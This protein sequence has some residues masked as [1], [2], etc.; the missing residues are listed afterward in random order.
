MYNVGFGD[1]FLL[2][3][4]YR[5]Q[6]GGDRHVLIDFGSFPR[7][8]GAPKNFMERVA[9]DIATR[10]QGGRLAVVAT[11]RHADHISGFATNA[12]HTASG[13]IIAA[14]KPEI[15]IQPWTEHPDA[16][17]DAHRAPALRRAAREFHRSLQALEGLA[18]GLV[19]DRRR[20][21]SFLAT[22]VRDQLAF[23]GENSISNKSAVKNLMR[24]GRRKPRYVHAGAQSGLTN[25][26]P[27]VKVR[28]L[29]PPTFEQAPEIRAYARKSDE[30]WVRL[31]RLVALDP[32]GDRASKS[33]NGALFGRVARHGTAGA[34]AHAAWFIKRLR[35]TYEEELLSIV[36]FLDDVLNN[37]S[38]ILLF[39]VGRQKLLFPGDAQLE[40]WSYALRK[41]R[42]RLKGVTVYKVG[43]HGSL[44]A[45]PKT[46][47]R[48]MTDGDAAV[49]P[50][51]FV[52]LMSSR[53]NV[54]GGKH[55][56]P[57]EVPR[58]PLVTALRERSRLV[59]T[60]DRDDFGVAQQVQ[61]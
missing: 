54:H 15:V 32:G 41:F 43:H 50:D 38:L 60:L 4:P 52:T 37:T 31:Q 47:W 8:K 9:R 16:A 11:H 6:D 23:L 13:D 35:R 56:R 17:T 10:C 59:T 36:T 20:L 39:E 12:K 7:P 5:Q 49:A 28:V 46:L 1:C 44:N 30:Y 58:G 21:P 18:A 2:T 34:P 33:G 42:A 48:I 26:L 55:G 45:T 22:D 29:G 27:G 51:H 25:V 24:M 57:T 19:A 3:F 53:S 14:I 40:N 61:V